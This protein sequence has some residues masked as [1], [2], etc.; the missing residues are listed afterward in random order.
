MAR[1]VGMSV[2]SPGLSVMG[3]VNT[4]PT[5]LTAV[6][7][8]NTLTLSWPSDYVGWRLQAQTNLLSTGL[9]TNW[10]DVPGSASVNSVN[11]NINPE[12]GAVFFRMVYP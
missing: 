11:V 6:V 12:N 9:G 3:S 1:P 8:G 4:T 7:T 10:A 5:N 2:R